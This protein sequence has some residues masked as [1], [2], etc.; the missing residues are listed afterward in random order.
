MRAI[1]FD[2]FGTLV[3][4]LPCSTW[5]QSS[6]SIAMALGVPPQTYRDLWE[7]KFKE[8]M[9]GEI[10]DGEQQ[11]DE[12]LELSGIEA[13]IEKRRS[14][15]RLHLDLLSEALIPKNE[16]CEVLE[17][18]V[19]R[20]LKLGLVTDCS[21]AAP[22]VLDKT[23]L[24]PFFTARSIS[25]FLGVRKPDP[26]MYSHVLDLLQVSGE[27][28]LYVGDGNSQELPGAKKF[29]M[30]TV[31]VDNGE[32]QHWRERFIPKGDYTVTSLE[33]LIPIL[34]SLEKPSN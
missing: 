4:N 9:T 5:E 33:Q 27:D 18:L 7:P 17:N 32:E 24:G 31:W 11:F 16:A 13:S 19:A 34:E 12:I 15:A 8:R 3:P 26:L 29:G 1:L 10:L 20:G 28:C 6:D 14:A 25:A 23:A 30:T 2:L 22:I 21:S